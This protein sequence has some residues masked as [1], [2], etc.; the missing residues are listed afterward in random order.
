M[1]YHNVLSKYIIKVHFQ[2]YFIIKPFQPL[3]HDSWI[4]WINP[5][6]VVK[7]QSPFEQNVE[8]KN[9]W[10]WRQKNKKIK[11]WTNIVDI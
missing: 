6:A 7:P 8:K 9:K 11:Y 2:N 1:Y 5:V 10:F 4:C 3:Q